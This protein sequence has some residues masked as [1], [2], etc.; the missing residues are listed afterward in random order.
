MYYVTYSFIE[1]IFIERCYL[2][3]GTKVTKIQVLLELTL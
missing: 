1:Q 3:Q 2:Q